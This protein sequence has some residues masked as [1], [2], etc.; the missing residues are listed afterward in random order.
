MRVINK[1][2]AKLL[3][4]RQASLPSYELPPET[5]L[6]FS[7]FVVMVISNSKSHGRLSPTPPKS[8]RV[9]FKLQSRTECSLPQCHAFTMWNRKPQMFRVSNYCAFQV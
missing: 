9:E 5:T 2:D 1:L 8:A 7:D 4:D 6:R 3:P